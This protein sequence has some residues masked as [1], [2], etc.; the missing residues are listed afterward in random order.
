QLAFIHD[1][2]ETNYNYQEIRQLS[3]QL[4]VVKDDTL[5]HGVSDSALN[6]W[7]TA[8]ADQHKREKTINDYFSKLKKFQSYLNNNHKDF[9]F[10]TVAEFIR[11]ISAMRRTQESYVAAIGGF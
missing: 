10:I 2:V 7:K 5:R 4:Q 3:R 1:A 6:S 9:I 11:S 8:L